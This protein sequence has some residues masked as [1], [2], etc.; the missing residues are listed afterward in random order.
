MNDLQKFRE[1]SFILSGIGFI[2]SFLLSSYAFIGFYQSTTPK[3]VNGLKFSVSSVN[4][5]SSYEG[6]LRFGLI[7][8]LFLLSALITQFTN[9]FLLKLLNILFL[10]VI[11][12]QGYIALR[13]PID[14]LY[15]KLYEDNFPLLIR[16]I[17]VLFCFAGLIVL[18][19]ILI[20]ILQTRSLLKKKSNSY[21][22]L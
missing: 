8:I 7:A 11:C 13:E 22:A 4:Y 21:L 1:K 3:T 5:D 12:F 17:A 10:A 14:A 6:F 18:P 2:T 20:I 9:N 19:A 16:I 15:F